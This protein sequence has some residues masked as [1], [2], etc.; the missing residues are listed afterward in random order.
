[1][2]LATVS[3]HRLGRE[4]LAV[5]DSLG[6]CALDHPLQRDLAACYLRD[7][8]KLLLV[9]MRD[10]VV[11]GA[12]SAI[13][14]VH[15]DKALQLFINEIGVAASCRGQGIGTKLLQGLLERGRLMGCIEARATA[16]EDNRS[17]RAL[18]EAVRGRQRFARAFVYTWPLCDRSFDDK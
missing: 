13:A 10:G 7:P 18:Y 12:G 5:L 8:D 6:D 15:P 17:A 9:A 11:I 1:M 14:S 16:E 3:I 2:A 4:D